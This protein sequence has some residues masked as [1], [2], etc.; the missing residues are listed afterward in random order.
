M[1][2]FTRIIY[3]TIFTLTLLIARYFTVDSKTAFAVTAKFWEQSTEKHFS[4]GNT[5]NVSISKGGHIKLAPKTEFI[6]GIEASYIWCMAKNRANNIFVGTGDPGVVYKITE[7]KSVE[8]LFRPPGEVHIQ[9]MVV[10]KEGT[11]YAAT[12]PD[13]TIFKI[14]TI[15]AKTGVL[16]KLPDSY[17]W[18]MVIDNRGYIYAATGPNGKIYRI[19]ETGEISTILDSEAT[20]ILDIKIHNNTIYACTE[21]FGLVY[22]I[23][24]EGE[25]NIIYDAKEEEVHC[26]TVT[27][28][29]TIFVGTADGGGSRLQPN[30][31]QPPNAIM[32]MLSQPALRQTITHLPPMEDFG[33]VDESSVN[34][35][36]PDVKA[37]NGNAILEALAGAFPTRN[38]ATKSNSVY[39]ISNDGSVRKI[40][41]LNSTFVFCI[42]GNNKNSIYVGT[43]NKASIYEIK[44]ENKHESQK[45]ITTLFKMEP[46]QILSLLPVNNNE[47]YVGTG[48]KGSVFKVANQFSTNGIYESPIL[49]TA[50]ISKWGRISYTM[51][52][53]DGT[54]LKLSTRSGNCSPPNETWSNWSNNSLSAKGFQE[55]NSQSRSIQ[56]P[57]AR[58][59]QYRAIFSTI[60]PEI[61]PVLTDVI[62]SY[63]PENQQPEITDLKI[64]TEQTPEP[65][66]SP[67]QEI[68][69]VP[70][71]IEKSVAPSVNKK[72]TWNVKDPDNDHL[73]Y[74]IY[75][76]LTGMDNWEPIVQDIRD[77]NDYVWNTNTIPGGKYLVKVEV[78]DLLNNP[79]GSSLQSKIVSHPFIVDNTV[80]I[81]NNIEMKLIDKNI[82]KISGT[83]SDETSNISSIQYSLNSL[84][85]NPIFPVDQIFDY[86]IEDFAVTIPQLQNGT[87]KIMLKATDDSGNT[88][89]NDVIIVTKTH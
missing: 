13:G 5:N 49:D 30:Q 3:I 18:N 38:R 19:S 15:G 40:I 6:R 76:K 89:E 41:D 62:I 85:W 17:V 71:T 67:V 79:E 33:L 36:T 26:L 42:A 47:F 21:P 73:Q 25:I 35:L 16:C 45:E 11:I 39:K 29:G 48:N 37:G 51:N 1:N 54:T 81:I 7:Q 56:N 86:K 63:L 22:R 43:A 50:G 66:I 44:V 78:D 75:Y 69:L 82:Y 65:S 53:K 10:D 32:A 8:E 84:D 34:N 58:F 12:S 55:S 24:P 77:R 14:S 88:G 61:T 72:I 2:N 31:Q 20:H 57:K 60:K 70:S 74:N 23:S 9:S 80:P 59:I 4:K 46:S 64:N 87:K 83:A 68:T 52:I 27:N 28:D